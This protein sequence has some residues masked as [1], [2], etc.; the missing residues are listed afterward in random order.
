[1]RRAIVFLEQQSWLGG[2][3]RVLEATIDTV[4]GDYD[5]IAAFPDSGSFRSALEQRNLETLDFPI[6]NYQPGR[7]SLVEMAAFAWRSLCCG[8]R[9]AFSFADD[10]SHSCMSM[11]RDVCL[12]VYSPHA[13]RA[14]L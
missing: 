7:K 14:V 5:C 10:G 11:A 13:S 12:P 6:G 1:M 8:L 4:Q 3:Q 9:L 2:A